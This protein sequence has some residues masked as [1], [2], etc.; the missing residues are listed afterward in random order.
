MFKKTVHNIK[1][2][3]ATQKNYLTG[4]HLNGLRKTVRQYLI[5]IKE[6][7]RSEKEFEQDLKDGA[8][9][10]EFPHCAECSVKRNG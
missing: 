6:I 8:Y 5:E 2:K 10:D 3:I 4:T 9:S 7:E 1:E